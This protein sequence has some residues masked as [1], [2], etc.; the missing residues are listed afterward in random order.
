MSRITLPKLQ[1]LRADGDKI[2]SVTG[3]VKYISTKDGF[4]AWLIAPFSA[5]DIVK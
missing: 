5:A 4:K 2:A 1:K 3:A